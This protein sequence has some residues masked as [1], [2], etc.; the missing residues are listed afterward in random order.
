MNKV[1]NTLVSLTKSALFGTALNLP[2]PL[3]ASEYEE[4]YHCAKH[5]GVMALCLDGIQRLPE[6]HQPDKVLKMKWIANV[7]AIE[8]RY[9][10]KQKALDML[11]DILRPDDIACMVFKGFSISRLYP[12]P[13][14]REFGDLDIFLYKD[15]SRGNTAFRKNGIHVNTENHHHA[16]CRINGILVENHAAF[17]HNSNSTFERKLEQIAQKVREEQQESPLFL[18]PLHHAAYIAHHASQHFFT[19]DCNIRLRTIC[20]WAVIL[21]GEG[22][23]WHYSDLKKLLQHTRETRMADIM[24]TICQHWYGNVSHDTRKQLKTF[25]ERNKNLFIK[26]IFAK[27]YQR[28]DEKRKWVRYL[29]HIYKQIVFKPLRK[30]LSKKYTK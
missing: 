4:L 20:D 21:Q 7:G 2:E 6:S 26:A 3:T 24:T 23:D 29:G 12:V 9:A 27:K 10:D 18:P 13:S 11:M 30:A 22:K 17:L 5:N 15:Y 1:Q 19:N 8:K 25:S 28:K 14:H 16:Q